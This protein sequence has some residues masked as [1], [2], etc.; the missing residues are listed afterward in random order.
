MAEINLS[1]LL[2]RN[3]N[4][5]SSISNLIEL[6]QMPVSVWDMDGKVSINPHY[7]IDDPGSEMHPIMVG[8]DQIGLVKGGEAASPIAGLLNS[9]VNFEVEKRA[10]GREVLDCYRELNLLYSL[11]EKLAS[12]FHL[13]EIA[14][15]TLQE[16]HRLIP[17]SLGA[18]LWVENDAEQDRC[19]ASFGDDFALEAWLNP[20]ES[21][22]R[23][24]AQ[25][26]RAEIYNNLTA[27]GSLSLGDSQI[28]SM[29]CAPLTT[30]SQSKT[31]HLGAIFLASQSE[32]IYTSGDLELLN[33]VST[34]AAPELEQAF[35]YEKELAEARRRE[36]KIRS[37]IQEL[38]IELD[39]A[40]LQKQYDEIT[41]DERFKRLR[42]MSANLRQIMNS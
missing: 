27:D 13:K 17:A 26:G 8:K 32:V 9:A 5:I 40:V 11:S 15:I 2:S 16:A 31:K 24:V 42:T 22:E 4:L 41:N 7:Q 35:L 33:T 19:L 30:K 21:M 39:S 28:H 37:Q 25:L 3:R 12:S 36:A 1:K 10:L 14:M 38:T 29:I 20:S 18:V 6:Y 23:G 34:Q